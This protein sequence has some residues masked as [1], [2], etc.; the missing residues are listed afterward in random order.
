M[1]GITQAGAHRLEAAFTL[2]LV[3]ALN[4]ALAGLWLAASDSVATLAQRRFFALR[5]A[6]KAGVLV[7]AV[8]WPVFAIQP[9]TR[10][11]VSLWDSLM[12]GRVL[13][14]TTIF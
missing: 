5:G 11:L 8:L 13:K 1:A 2:L 6:V 3:L 14:S 4:Y 9:G 12:F 10:V 7:L